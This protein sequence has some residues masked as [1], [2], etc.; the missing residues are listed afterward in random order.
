[1]STMNPSSAPLEATANQAAEPMGIVS[2]GAWGAG[3]QQ[4]CASAAFFPV[5]SPGTWMR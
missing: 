5:H 1:M 4:P 3:A 2:E